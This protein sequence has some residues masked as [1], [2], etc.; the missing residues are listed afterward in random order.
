MDDRQFLAARMVADT[1]A[2]AAAR[3]RTYSP[4]R[5]AAIGSNG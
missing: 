5:P 2:A 3:P 4:I 1:V